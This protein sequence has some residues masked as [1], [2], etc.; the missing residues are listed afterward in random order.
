MSNESKGMS[1]VA[2]EAVSFIERAAPVLDKAAKLEASFSGKLPQVV[3]AMVSIGAI[4]DN[5]KQAKLIQFKDDPSAVCDLL[6]SIASRVET[7]TSMGK[8]AEK[9][10]PEKPMNADEYFV[11]RMLSG[12]RSE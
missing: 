5:M 6:L 9:Q 10:D 8:A 1:K 3:D 4:K 12:R 11:H 2:A 7:P